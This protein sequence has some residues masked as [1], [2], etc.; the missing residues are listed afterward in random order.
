MLPFIV[1]DVEDKKCVQTTLNG[2]SKPLFLVVAAAAATCVHLSEQFRAVI[3]NGNILP[4]FHLVLLYV[5]R[6]KARNLHRSFPSQ[7]RLDRRVYRCLAVMFRY[8]QD[9]GSIHRWVLY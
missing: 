8:F 2:L 5:A 7:R 6:G 1:D 3:R 9:I 4:T